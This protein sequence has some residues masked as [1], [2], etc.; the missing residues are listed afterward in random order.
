M[1]G[2]AGQ[3]AETA[4]FDHRAFAAQEALEVHPRTEGAARAGE[5]RHA[6]VVFGVEPVERGGN[7]FRRRL[8]H[9]VFRFGAVD[10]DDEHAV[11]HLGQKFLA[12]SVSPIGIAL[13]PMLEKRAQRVKRRRTMTGGATT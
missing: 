9:R 7:A 4:P 1:I 13:K 10:G 3:P 12:H 11:L 5:H 8:V 6:Q 2:L